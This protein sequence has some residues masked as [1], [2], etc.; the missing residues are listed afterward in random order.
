MGWVEIVEERVKA[1]ESLFSFTFF[2][3]RESETQTNSD[4]E[5]A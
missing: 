3:E 2:T 1:A 5:N 4:V